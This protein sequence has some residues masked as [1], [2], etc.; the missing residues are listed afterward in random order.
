MLHSND[1]SIHVFQ[2][3]CI[4]KTE[5]EDNCVVV[6]C[7]IDLMFHTTPNQ[8]QKFLNSKNQ[9]PDCDSNHLTHIP[10]SYSTI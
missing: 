9:Q 5:K 8:E 4:I 2:I 7:Y 1:E 6:K 3:L 10:N